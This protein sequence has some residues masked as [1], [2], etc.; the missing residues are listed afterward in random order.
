MRH[1]HA[2]AQAVDRETLIQLRGCTAKGFAFDRR[3]GV[4]SSSDAIYDACVA[5][6]VE[7]LFKV[8]GARL[9]GANTPGGRMRARGACGTCMPAPLWQLQGR[10]ALARG[11]ACGLQAAAAVAQA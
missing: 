11:R 9:S 10:L 3:F 4:D 6:L 7:N 2:T 8:G 1:P 5:G